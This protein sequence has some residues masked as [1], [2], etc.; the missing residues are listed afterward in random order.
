MGKATLFYDVTP[1][2]SY[3]TLQDPQTVPF[4]IFY[5]PMQKNP[6]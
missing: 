3:P 6:S 5:F 1:P 2:K 4:L